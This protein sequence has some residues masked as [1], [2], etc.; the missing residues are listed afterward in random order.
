MGIERNKKGDL[1]NNFLGVLIAVIGIGLLIFGAVKIWSVGFNQEAGNAKSVMNSLEAK[2]NLINAGESGNILL[3]G[4]EGAE[5]WYIFGFDK[6]NSLRPDKCFF[7]SC[8]CICRLDEF[9]DFDKRE[10]TADYVSINEAGVKKCQSSGFC[11]FF[12]DKNVKVYRSSGIEKDKWDFYLTQLIIKAKFAFTNADI[13]LIPN[14]R[15]DNFVRLKQGVIEVSVTKSKE[16]NIEME[17]KNPDYLV[18][19]SMGT[20]SPI[21]I[22]T[23]KTDKC[24]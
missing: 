12:G 19:C 22:F 15:F 5:N 2:I 10:I 24:K 9:S 6:S 11:R 13:A 3:Q 4:F 14:L 21:S 20:I 7:K 17:H 1:M 8:I 18:F 16:G 23:D